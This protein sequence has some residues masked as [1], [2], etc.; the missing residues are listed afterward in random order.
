MNM[1]MDVTLGGLLESVDSS[2]LPDPE[3]FMYY[4]FL[5][6]RKI[7]ISGEVCDGFIERATLPYLEMDRDGSGKPIEII[8]STNGG[9]LYD[10]F[11]LI[12][13]IERAVTPTT[14]RIVGMALSMGTLI[15]M[16]GKNNPNVKT[17]CD[18][19]SIGLLHSGSQ[20]MEGT[21]H[22]VKDLFDFTQAYEAKIKRFILS[23][24]KIDEEYYDKIERVELWLDAET[25]LKLG[26]V[27]EILG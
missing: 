24:S 16:A 12:D 13:Q 10:G 25:M 5:N 20:Y 6:D 3:T 17:V 14:I 18:P 8:V 1:D 15:A 7:I 2:V 27:D 9:N 22:A 19:F 4:K 21:T 26:I 23:H 11:S